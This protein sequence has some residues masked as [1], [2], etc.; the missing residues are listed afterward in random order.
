MLFPPAVQHVLLGM[1]ATQDWLPLR[2]M[3]ADARMGIT[4]AAVVHL[5]ARQ[6]IHT[7]DWS[8]C[9]GDAA[10]VHLRGIV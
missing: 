4:D 9:S 6:S 1:L 10:L 5:P 8:G 2:A 3:S 7:L